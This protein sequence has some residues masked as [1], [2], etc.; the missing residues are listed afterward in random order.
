MAYS[1][2]LPLQ[3]CVP[4]TPAHFPS[5]KVPSHP[6]PVPGDEW[7]GL[8][9]TS[10]LRGRTGRRRYLP[11]SEDKGPSMDRIWS[12]HFSLS[13]PWRLSSPPCRLPSLLYHLHEESPILPAL[14]PPRRISYPLCPGPSWNVP[15]PLPCVLL[16]GFPVS[17]PC[18]I[19]GGSSH[20]PALPLM[21]PSPP[22]PVP[23]TEG[24]FS[25][26]PPP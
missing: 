25:S 2:A 7:A 10:P 19:H 24:P 9:G 8:K 16:G 13:P 1:S 11:W 6:C 5:W 14:P 17:L 21:V 15:L 23:S 4:P 20:L 3:V 22:C 26:L 18:P 12:S